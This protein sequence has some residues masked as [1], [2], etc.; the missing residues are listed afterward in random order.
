MGRWR[1]TA[2]GS[3][4]LE[5]ICS[6]ATTTRDYFKHK[7]SKAKQSTRNICKTLFEYRNGKDL[8]SS[9][10]NINMV[11]L[12]GLEVLAAG[13]LIKQHL[14]HKEE[15]QRLEIEALNLEE[16]SY[17]IYS[18]DRAG[19]GIDEDIRQKEKYTYDRRERYDKGR[20]SEDIRYTNSPPPKGYYAPRPRSRENQSQMRP[21]GYS[22]TGA[23]SVQWVPP[24]P[25]QQQMNSPPIITT[26]P[27]FTRNPQPYPAHSVSPPPL[28]PTFAN[29]PYAYPPE[30]TTRVDAKTWIAVPGEDELTVP[31]ETRDP[32]PA[33]EE[34]GGRH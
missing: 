7:Q 20:S 13:Y 29:E 28:H 6:A 11:L 14:K 33:Y 25:P 18:P 16:Q 17:R 30:K 15:K 32:P 3:Q 9:R 10:N 2:L 23:S 5:Q 8:Y 21:T 22:S 24:P 1:L 27:P 12:G 19:P 34:I 26:I 4:G 31:G